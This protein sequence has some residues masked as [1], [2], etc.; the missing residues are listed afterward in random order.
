MR[1]RWSDG[2]DFVVCP[3]PAVPAIPGYTVPRHDGFCTG[4]DELCNANE[5]PCSG[6]D[7]IEECARLCSVNAR[8]ISFEYSQGNTCQ[9]STS[10]VAGTLDDATNTYWRVY[11]KTAVNWDNLICDVNGWVQSVGPDY[12]KPHLLAAAVKLAIGSKGWT[13]DVTGYGGWDLVDFQ[14]EPGQTRFKSTTGTVCSPKDHNLKVC[15]RCPDLCRQARQDLSAAVALVGVAHSMQGPNYYGTGLGINDC[16]LALIGIRDFMSSGTSTTTII[17]TTTAITTGTTTQTTSQSTR[18]TKTG[19]HSA[20][21]CI[22][23]TAH[24]MLDA[25]C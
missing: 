22:L 15:T 9:M 1:H 14:V 16:A 4:R 3:C 20:H 18:Y 24:H 2:P 7:T 19:M 8:C 25:P 17:Q 12:H 23:S 13:L 11:V 5:A 21:V 6:A 10:C